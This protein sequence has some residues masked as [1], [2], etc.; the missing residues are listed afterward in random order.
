MVVVLGLWLIV[1]ATDYSRST[2]LKRP[3]FA[4]RMESTSSIELIRY[5][6]MV[7]EVF[8][9]VDEFNQDGSAISVTMKMLGKV[10]GASI[11]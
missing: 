9:E 6:G 11:Q 3:V 2:N 1:F 5:Q 8:V 7:Y 4:I 10:I